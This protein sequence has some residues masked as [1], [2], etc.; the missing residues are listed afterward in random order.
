MGLQQERWYRR[1]RAGVLDARPA[2]T[3]R[4]RE[5]AL[6]TGFHHIVHHRAERAAALVERIECWYSDADGAEP[7]D[8]LRSPAQPPMS[9]PPL[10]AIT[11]PVM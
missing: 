4:D 6:I 11:E 1:C 3:E 9:R 8:E 5:H 2:V 10:T 7:P